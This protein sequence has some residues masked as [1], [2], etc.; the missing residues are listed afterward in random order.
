MSHATELPMYL[1][2]DGLDPAPE[3]GEARESASVQRMV[4]AYGTPAYVVTRY[5]D[6]KNALADYERF[7]NRRPTWP[8]LLNSPAPPDIADDQPEA[9]SAGGLLA[10]DP[11][12]HTRLRRMLSSEFTM[13]RMNQ[14]EPW[15]VEIVEQHLN[16][17][18]DAGP[19][20]DLVEQFALPI[21]SLVICEL[22]GVPYD[23]REGFQRR[24]ARQLDLARPLPERMEQA[25]Q[26][27]TYMRSLVERARRE[28]GDD[29]LGTL[30]RKY[31]GDVADAEL[32]GIGALLLLAGHETTSN[33]LALGTL[34]LLEHPEQL[35]AVRDTPDAVGPAVE[36]LLRYLS[37]VQTAI[38][39]ITATDVEID[40]VTIPAG[41]LVLL[42]MP[43]ANRDPRFIES[44]ETLDIRRGEP[45]HL[46]FG[47]GVHH[48]LGAP[49]ARMEMRIAFPALLRRFP[50]LRLAADISQIQFKKTHFIYGVR[51][52]GVAW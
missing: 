49:L 8:G 22:L 46:A 25:L 35:A 11:P 17:M 20:A 7:S 4:T 18:E 38:P 23:E 43:V 27:R 39:R 42:S 6:V 26:G 32:T 14:L 33:M 13:R 48:C 16:A 15:A 29:I 19:P 47:H 5:L 9:D 28:P 31:G 1:R 2:R 51:S 10:M 34:A 24:S 30:V 12:D 41:Q 37:V 44:P 52:L 40:G 45:G 21:P 3:L 36:E 50:R